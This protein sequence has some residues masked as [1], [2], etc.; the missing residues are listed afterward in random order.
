MRRTWPFTAAILAITSIASIAQA[1]RPPQL[2]PEY[3]KWLDEDVRWIMTSQERQQFLNLTSVHDRDDFVARFWDERNPTPGS[4]ENAF[5]EEHYRR[6][7]FANEHFASAV[8]GWRTDRGR[9]YIVYGPP[10]SI[11]V[12]PGTSAAPAEEIWLY[13]HMQREGDDVRLKFV[14]SCRCGGYELETALPNHE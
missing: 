5:K 2:S 13:H 11:A 10:D 3:K 7:A 14:D 12:Q 9:I 4:K 6:L 1:G 8:A